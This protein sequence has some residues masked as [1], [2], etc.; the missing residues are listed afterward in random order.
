MRSRGH[1]FLVSLQVTASITMMGRGAGSGICLIQKDFDS[2]EYHHN[3]QPLHR[4]SVCLCVCVS[5][6]T[7]GEDINA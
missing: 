6:S 2:L 3:C 7:E 1:G 4:G 5:V